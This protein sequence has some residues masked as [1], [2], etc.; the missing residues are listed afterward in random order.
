MFM[1]SETLNKLAAP[2]DPKEV[3]W[4]P[5]ISSSDCT[6]CR[7]EPYVQWRSYIER[8]NAVLTPAGWEHHLSVYRRREGSPDVVIGVECT[9][10]IRGVGSFRGRGEIRAAEKRAAIRAEEKSLKDACSRFGLDRSLRAVSARVEGRGLL[11][12]MAAGF[13]LSDAGSTVDRRRTWEPNPDPTRTMERVQK[14][15]G[16]VL[17][18]DVL[19][20][21]GQSGKPHE[22]PLALRNQALG[23][24]RT[25]QRS[26]QEAKSL[27]AGIPEHVFFTL[28]EDYGISSLCEVRSVEALQ[29]LLRDLRTASV[30]PTLN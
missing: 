17:Y 12:R 30:V 8:L 24:M 25:I 20:Q 27:I 1:Y 18:R 15:I 4:Y 14:D 6:V 10:I 5:A 29:N 16:E 11:H 26:L 28:L 7:F 13:G 19:R 21:I 3:T 23:K 9:L 22:L 2:F